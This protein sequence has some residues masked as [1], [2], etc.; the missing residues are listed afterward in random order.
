M[1]SERMWMVRAGQGAYLIDDFRSNEIVAIGWDKITDLSRINNPEEVKSLLKNTYPDY[2]KGRII[3]KKQRTR[4]RQLG[5]IPLNEYF[6]NCEA[7]HISENFVIYIP[8]KIHKSISH[9]I[10]TWRNM[11]VM[12]RLAFSFL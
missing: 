5:W 6:H 12:N 8:K 11:N 7:H 4:H 2:K 10:W 1:S 9:N 3:I